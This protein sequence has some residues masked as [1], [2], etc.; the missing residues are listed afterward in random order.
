M[1]LLANASFGQQ[2]SDPSP[3]TPQL[4]QVAKFEHQVTGVTVSK[5]GRIF[6]NFP[7]WTEDAPVSVAE[8]MRDG[9]IKPY[10]PIRFPKDPTGPSTL[11]APVSRT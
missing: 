10:W 8:V 6:V 4:Q 7:R 1:T 2:R 9:Q 11:P 3:D 5:D